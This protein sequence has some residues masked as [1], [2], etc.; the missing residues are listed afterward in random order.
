MRPR[1][2]VLCPGGNAG[3]RLQWIPA[4]V[5]VVDDEAQRRGFYVLVIQVQARKAV[6]SGV[7]PTD[8][9][10]GWMWLVST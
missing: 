7:S 2:I 9:V 5:L 3:D 1:Q 6:S 10:P 4:H 8:E